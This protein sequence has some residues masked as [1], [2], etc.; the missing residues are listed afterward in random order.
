MN[1]GGNG[2]RQKNMIKC[3]YSSSVGLDPEDIWDE[4]VILRNQVVTMGQPD[5]RYLSRKEGIGKTYLVLAKYI[6]IHI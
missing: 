6:T 2:G 5:E 4:E 3:G 1:D